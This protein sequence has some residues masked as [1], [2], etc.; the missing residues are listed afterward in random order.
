MTV[1]RFPQIHAVCRSLLLLALGLGLA[2][3]PAF[4]PALSQEAEQ[5]TAQKSPPERPRANPDE[6]TWDYPELL[7]VPSASTLVRDYAQ[8]EPSRSLMSY[9]PLQLMALG[10]IIVGAKAMGEKKI[11]RPDGSISRNPPLAGQI[12]LGVGAVTIGGTYLLSQS[13]TPYRDGVRTLKRFGGKSQKARL[14]KEREAEFVIDGAA[15]TATS[16]RILGVLANAA[17]AGNILGHSEDENTKIGAA[18]TILAG[19]GPFMFTPY[20]I[21]LPGRYDGY[22]KRIYGPVSFLSATPGGLLA[23]NIGWQLRF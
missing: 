20:Q 22:K 7:A 11:Y 14:A 6:P 1:F 19:I 8:K 16:V 9:I 23:G 15:S 5:Q 3:G 21:E 4:S 12:A 10:N 17:V 13:Y 2:F 18:L